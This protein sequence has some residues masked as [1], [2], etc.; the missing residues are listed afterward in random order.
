MEKILELIIENENKTTQEKI[1]LINELYRLK[2]N[3]NTNTI[4]RSPA[5]WW[6]LM[7]PR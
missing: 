2:N 4:L 3:S 6:Q 5:T 7:N 1:E